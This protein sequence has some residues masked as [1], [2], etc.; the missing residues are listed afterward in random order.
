V[1]PA[2][3]RPFSATLHKSSLKQADLKIS[4]MFG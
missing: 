1:T 2:A 4:N 3:S